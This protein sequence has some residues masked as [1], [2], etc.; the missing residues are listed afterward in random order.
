MD[1]VTNEDI[2]MVKYFYLEKGDI[3]RWNKWGERCEVIRKEYPELIHA[4]EKEMI[5]KR[6]AKHQ[7]ERLEE[8]EE[9]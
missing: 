3:T 8:K 4:I 1:Q 7:I 5:Y 2:R 6:W 9:V